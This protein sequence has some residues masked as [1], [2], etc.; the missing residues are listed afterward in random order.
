MTTAAMHV[1]Q[2]TDWLGLLRQLVCTINRPDI[3]SLDAF[4]SKLTGDANAALMLLRLLYW[5]PKSKREGWIYKSWRDWNAECNLS[6]S[7]IKRVHSLNLLEAIGIVR[8]IRKANGVPTMHYRLDPVAFLRQIGE[9]LG[10]DLE[11]LEA[12]SGLSLTDQSIGSEQP[13]PEGDLDPTETVETAKPITDIN[14]QSLHPDNT[15]KTAASIEDNFDSTELAETNLLLLALVDSG[16]DLVT[17]HW[18]VSRYENRDI[19]QVLNRAEEAAAFN[20]PGFI[21]T[22]LRDSWE[23]SCSQ[24]Q[25]SKSLVEL[26][27]DGKRYAEGKYAEFIES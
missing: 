23:L 15:N 20:P 4:L 24:S 10:L 5:T 13:S 12:L 6:Q 19:R 2:N 26:P 27:E 8:E 22:A 3:R 1:S 9:Y 11:Q 18:L 21:L 17:S 7:Q 14:Q 16:F 25:K